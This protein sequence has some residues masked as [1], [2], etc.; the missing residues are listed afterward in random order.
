MTY[1]N[2]QELITLLPEFVEN[3]NI[4][5]IRHIFEEYNIV[6]LAEIFNN[7]ELSNLVFVFRILPKTISGE[8]FSYL[9]N[10]LKLKL[11]EM[12]SSRDVTH[13]FDNMFSDDIVDFLEEL[14]ANV[15]KKIL[16]SASKEQRD[17]IN[18]LL[19]YQEFTAGSIMS[20]DY[21]EL[22]NT[23]NVQ[24][25]IQVVKNEANL[26]DTINVCY[27]VDELRNYLGV[28]HLRDLIVSKNTVL[29]TSLIEETE[30]FVHTDTDQEEVVRK[31]RE[32]DITSIPVL[33]DQNRLIGI[34]T[35]DDVLDVLVEEATEDIHKMSV[36]SYV[37]GSYL[38][39]NI[40]DMILSRVGWLLILMI[41]ASFTGTILQIF[42]NKLSVATILAVSIPVIMSTS[43]NAGSQ[44]SATIIRSIS[45]DNLSL[46]TD[47]LKVLKK[48]LSV[49]L[50]CGGIIFIANILRIV[51][52]SGLN[53]FEVSLVVSLTLFISLT[54]ANLV[55]ASLPL[56]A[57]SLKLDPATMA[58]PIITTII[59]ATSLSIYFVLAILIL[60][61]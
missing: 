32:Y 57:K 14:P 27:V 11:V 20:T 40:K 56:I 39:M 1:Y 7:L 43:G 34:I 37:E 41:S 38:K 13:L 2:K 51:A 35:A 42:E 61:I 48:E 58:S 46:K 6:D 23:Q 33:N 21:I 24:E 53:S 26:A 54:L 8:F 31:L 16:A 47:L 49:S 3:K 4:M 25:A 44:S 22:E 9:D 52:V 5:K 50:I 12:L 10:D 15:I 55:G 30:I 36:I 19:S 17:E 18:A 29:V 45:T 60:R 59:D 28:V